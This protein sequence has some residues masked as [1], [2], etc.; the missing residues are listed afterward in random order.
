M[1][2]AHRKFTT[3]SR[4]RYF[5][6]SR[7]EMVNNG[8]QGCWRKSRTTRHLSEYHSFKCDQQNL[9][10]IRSPRLLI[11]LFVLFPNS[12]RDIHNITIRRVRW[13]L[14]GC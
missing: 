14:I 7:S 12:E 2:I 10:K 8:K 13:T 6:R 3:M 9:T 11:S 1:I 5:K 4:P